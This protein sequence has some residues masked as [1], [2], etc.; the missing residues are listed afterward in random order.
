MRNGKSGW[1]PV[2]RI[3]EKEI[4]KVAREENLKDG[5]IILKRFK[6]MAD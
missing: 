5:F 4:N 1:Q 2:V 6:F 3:N